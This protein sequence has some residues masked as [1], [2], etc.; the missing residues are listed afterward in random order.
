MAQGAKP[1]EGGQ[2][3][4]RKVY[5]EIAKVRHSTPGVG[6]IS[7]PPHH[8]IYSIEDLA[9]L[10]HD[11]KNAN[12]L[13]RI[14]VKLVSEV[15]VGTVAAGVAKAHADVILI[16]GH[17]GGT[18]AS[19]QT[20][21]KHAG[22]P[23]ELLW[24][25]GPTPMLLG[26]GATAACVRRL[27]LAQAIPPPRQAAGPLRILAVSPRAGIPDE[28]RQI[29]RAARAAAWAPMIE[30]GLAHMQE[31]SPVTRE[32]LA[33]ATAGD[34]PPDVIHYYGHGRYSGGEGAL[35]LDDAGAAAWVPAAAL[36]PL[37]APAGMVVLHACQGAMLGAEDTPAT[38]MRTALAPAL[39]AAGVPIVL[40]MQFTL[41]TAAANRMVAVIYQALAEG[42]SVEDAVAFARRALYVEEPDRVSWYVPALY[43]RARAGGP[44]Y[45]RPPAPRQAAEPGRPAGASQAVVARAGG[46][47]SSLRMRGGSGSR[48]VVIAEGGSIS[49]VDVSN[50]TD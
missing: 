18:G 7:P 5:P 4:G 19:P 21:I 50:H 39:C 34:H 1:G 23:W 37:L 26:R 49:G 11:L 43:L 29:E 16:S 24:D 17:D 30:R 14:N 25:E 44:A 41:R 9:Q 8:D 46:A 20:A 22:L 12:P 2:L 6:L 32:T 40:G 42:R 13:A 31:L 38:D 35:L 3:P 45:L 10:I 47:I 48:Q 28:L 33:R 15:G 27:D 36:A